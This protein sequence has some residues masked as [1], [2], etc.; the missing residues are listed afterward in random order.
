MLNACYQDNTGLVCISL[1]SL[2]YY[3]LEIMQI[4]FIYKYS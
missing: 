4:V 3:E 1:F 2:F